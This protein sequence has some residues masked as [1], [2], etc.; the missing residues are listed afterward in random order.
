MQ[1]SSSLLFWCGP[2]I[3]FLFKIAEIA[4]GFLVWSYGDLCRNSTLPSHNCTHT[5]L[6]YQAS[7][8]TRDTIPYRGGDQRP[9]GRFGAR[10]ICSSR[11]LVGLIE[12]SA[13]T[14]VAFCL[15]LLALVRGT[16]TCVRITKNVTDKALGA[17]RCIWAASGRPPGV[18]RRIYW[19]SVTG[20]FTGQIIDFSRTPPQCTISGYIDV[21]Y[22]YD[23]KASGIY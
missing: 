22:R 5:L 19:S 4:I 14:G 23:R 2:E 16:R 9:P 6:P 1:H 8:D 17:S 15:A 12:D 18:P 13:M 21:Y 11:F 10:M 7:R 3:F 20:H